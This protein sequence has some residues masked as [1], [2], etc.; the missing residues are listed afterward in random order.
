M[1]RAGAPIRITSAAR[2]GQK[3]MKNRIIGKV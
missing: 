2:I 1:G 3:T